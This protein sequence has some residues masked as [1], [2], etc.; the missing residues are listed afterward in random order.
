MRRQSLFDGALVH[1]H[2]IGSQFVVRWWRRPWC[3]KPAGGPR[4]YC[5]PAYGMLLFGFLWWSGQVM[6]TRRQKHDPSIPAA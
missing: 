2:G 4:F 6:P 3:G 1:E 5:H